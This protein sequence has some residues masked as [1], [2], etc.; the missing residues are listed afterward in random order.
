MALATPEMALPANFATRFTGTKTRSILERLERC[1]A[2]AAV[3]ASTRGSSDIITSVIS[4]GNA[5][6]GSDSDIGTKE[7]WATRDGDDV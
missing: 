3:R 7:R 1:L 5:M 4:S 6:G 2:M